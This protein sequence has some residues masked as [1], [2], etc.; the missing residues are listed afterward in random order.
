LKFGETTNQRKARKNIFLADGRRLKIA[1]GRRE[2][3]L[4]ER[5]D[6]RRSARK[7][8]DGFTQLIAV[9]RR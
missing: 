6:L 4:L 1:D 3:I 5:K 8:I 7:E 2:V 9:N